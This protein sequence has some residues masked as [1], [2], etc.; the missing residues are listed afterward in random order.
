MIV[1]YVYVCR[2][3]LNT[4]HIPFD[5]CRSPTTYVCTYVCTRYVHTYVSTNH[6]QGGNAHRLSELWRNEVYLLKMRDVTGL[7]LHIASY[8][9]E[10]DKA[11]I[12]LGL[13]DA[14]RLVI[15]T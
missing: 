13:G 4:L 1:Y 2:H 11:F 14:P 8:V 7:S 12:Q 9:G 3:L 15:F 6:S 5:Q 10:G